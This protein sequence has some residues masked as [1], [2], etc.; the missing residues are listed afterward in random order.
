MTFRTNEKAKEKVL[1]PH[2]DFFRPSQ[3][4]KKSKDDKINWTLFFLLFIFCCCCRNVRKQNHVERFKKIVKNMYAK[5]KERIKKNHW[6]GFKQRKITNDNK[7]TSIFL[8]FFFPILCF[9]CILYCL[10]LTSSNSVSA[11]GLNTLDLSL[12]NNNGEKRNL[13]FLFVHFCNG[14]HSMAISILFSLGEDWNVY[15]HSML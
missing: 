15:I 13:S 8:Y 2:R 9:I 3:S 4:V 5:Q 12:L 14:L 6:I 11:G 1:W 7:F 10:F